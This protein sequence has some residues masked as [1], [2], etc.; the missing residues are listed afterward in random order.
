MAAAQ[1]HQNIAKLTPLADVLAL[2]A[3]RVQPVAQRTVELAAAAGCVLAADVVAAARPAKPLALIDGWAVAADATRD[4]GGYAP[5]MLP[6]MPTR[7][8][9]GEAMPEGTDS[10]APLDAVTVSAS[11][12]EALAPVNPGDG[13]LPA[14]G[15]CDSAQPLRRAGER[16]RPID[17]AVLACAGVGEVSVRVPHLRVVPVRSDGILDS[18]ARWIADDG[19]RHGAA[20]DESHRGLDAALA[21]DSADII[22]G[23]GGTGSGRDDRSVH[24][25]AGAGRVAVHGIALT[26]GET[27]AFGWVGNRPVL[28]LPGRLDA[29]LAVWLTLGRSLL[30]RLAGG[31]SELP[32]MKLPLARK[33]TSA[34]GLAELVLVRRT[35]DMIEPLASKFLSLSA[36]ARADGFVLVPAE[37]EGYSAGASV[38]VSLWA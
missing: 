30:Q 15:D 6:Q 14:G 10:V 7:I 20:V 11:G 3:A 8:D 18:A 1:A 23:I 38:S 32:A 34:V 13:V 5:A 37:S 31:G 2:I 17:L 25:L 33:V 27:A 16:S 19:A 4:A 9:V 36:L 28:L 35:A 29:G 22:V 24:W 12:A 21:D 26:P